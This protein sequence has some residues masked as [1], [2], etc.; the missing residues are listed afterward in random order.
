MICTNLKHFYAHILK[1]H[2][3]SLLE[4]LCLRFLGN[5]DTW[6]YSSSSVHV[7]NWCIVLGS[8]YNF[9][10]FHTSMAFQVVLLKNCEVLCTMTFT[11]QKEQN[12]N[13]KDSVVRLWHCPLILWFPLE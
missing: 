4:G 3:A 5:L 2:R 11:H 8:R 10:N 13:N 9:C 6:C 7:S 12:A 1:N